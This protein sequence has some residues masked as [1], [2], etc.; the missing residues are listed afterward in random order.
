MSNKSLKYLIYGG[1]IVTFFHDVDKNVL[2]NLAKNSSVP[3][4]SQIL[5]TVHYT[6]RKL[7]LFN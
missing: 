1:S 3:V 4:K 5:Y 7:C 2:K 6:L